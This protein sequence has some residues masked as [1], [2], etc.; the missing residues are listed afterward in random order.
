MKDE[1]K[2]L[3]D[4]IVP[5]AKSTIV[6]ILAR[7]NDDKVAMEISTRVLEAAGKMQPARGQQTI[8]INDSDVKILS[9]GMQE[10]K[11]AERLFQKGKA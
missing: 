4:D 9:I 11:D 7:T 1:Y 3:F 10:V 6:G 5:L 8:V 2:G